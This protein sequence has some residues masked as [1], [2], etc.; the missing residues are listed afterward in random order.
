MTYTVRYERDRRE[1]IHRGLSKANA[2]ALA[3]YIRKTFRLAVTVTN[4][5]VMAV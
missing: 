2:E 1:E 4:D 3:G 5:R